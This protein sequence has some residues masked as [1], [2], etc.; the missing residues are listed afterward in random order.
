M[1]NTTIFAAISMA[2]VLSLLSCSDDL[3]T[4]LIE[5]PAAS[6]DKVILTINAGSPET[7]A[8]F[9]AKGN[10]GYPI[11][12]SETGE[13]IRVAEYINGGYPKHEANSSSCTV[14]NEGK[15]ASFSVVL[16]NE[17]TVGTYDYRVISRP[18]HNILFNDDCV[19]FDI[20]EH[21]VPT[22]SSPDPE[23]ILLYGESLGHTA[24]RTDAFSI[25]FR[26]LSAFG[27]VTIL[28]GNKP[29]GKTSYSYGGIVE[30]ITSITLTVPAGKEYYYWG[31]G[32][33]K[34]AASGVD[35]ITVSTE[36][37]NTSGDFEV[38]FAC[39]PYSLAAGD[40][41]T[42]MVN[43][44]L[45]LTYSRT[46]TL[47]SALS[48]SLG[49][50]SKFAVDMENAKLKNYAGKYLI[51]GR[52]Y[53]SNRWFLMGEM[54]SS[55]HFRAQATSLTETDP[56]KVKDASF[57]SELDIDD[58]IWQISFS[59]TA[60][61]YSFMKD[62]KYLAVSQYGLEWVTYEDYTNL[63]TYFTITENGDHEAIIT[64]MSKG[65]ELLFLRQ[66]D[67]DSYFGLISASGRR[68]FLIPASYDSRTKVTL[69]FAEATVDCAMDDD[70]SV[71]TVTSSASIS[72][73]TYSMTGD[74]IGTIDPATGKITLNHLPG[75]VTVKAS[76][77]GDENYKPANSSYTLNVKGNFDLVQSA[78]AF[79]VGGKYILA[80][81]DGSDGHYEFISSPPF[82]NTSP[83]GAY[84]NIASNAMAVTEG[85][86]STPIARYIFEVQSITAEG[87]SFVSYD[88]KYIHDY[89]NSYNE[90]STHYS[91]NSTAWTA[92]YLGS[93]S[94]TYKLVSPNGRF[95]S[96]CEN[97]TEA[98]NV[99]YHQLKAYPETN[100][101]DQVA[102]HKALANYSGAISVFRYRDGQTPVETLDAPVLTGNG[103]KV[104]MVSAKW[105]DDA[106]A[107]SGY[108]CELYT[109]G[110]KQAEQ[111][112][113]AGVENV[114][115]D[116]LT[117]PDG[118]TYTIKVN[119][120]AVNGAIPY[121]ASA[122]S[123]LDIVAK[124]YHA[125]DVTAPGK[126]II[127]GLTVVGVC[128][129]YQI[130]A[131]DNT[132]LVMIDTNY[133]QDDFYVGNIIT[134]NGQASWKNGTLRFGRK[135]CTKTGNA[136]TPTYSDPTTMTDEFLAAYAS[137]PSL[138][139]VS[140]TGVYDETFSYIHIGNRKLYLLN[141]QN[142]GYRGNAVYIEGYL[143]GYDS[144]TSRYEFIPTSITTKGTLQVTPK[145][146]EDVAAD[147]GT[148]E[149]TVSASGGSGDWTYS[150]YNG[151]PDWVQT[152]RNGNTL[153]IT[154]SKNTTNKT[155]DFIIDFQHTSYPELTRRIR[156][157]QKQ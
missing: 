147:G 64:S 138:V 113:A 141:Y 155:R 142:T 10:D 124:A 140:G 88:G 60:K 32:L 53:Y 109:G 46:I 106:R 48:F 108:H 49:N 13:R 41:L 97:K 84:C 123:S 92:T 16:T 25:D 87:I 65:S 34:H 94:G 11:T 52:D 118:T 54:V 127:E 77:A 105:T 132:G 71:Q 79:V 130:V 12:W 99:Y 134:V 1:K 157:F 143:Y 76:F 19:E 150:F 43:T 102:D 29:L 38:W 126:Y 93:A 151:A 80:F 121:A 18:D 107:S 129:Y 14:S 36:N 47:S 73:I 81:K 22:A 78:G 56:E 83:D 86:I 133:N 149:F 45:G 125:A 91:D 146:V 131:R 26:H 66:T 9:G 103:A 44:D 120:K 68:C 31:N 95:L 115:F 82:K 72:G 5:K 23:G 69:S 74:N 98:N 2:L 122:V 8:V 21:Q 7:K 61:G 3:Q 15:N 110:V 137:S 85:V 116:G 6:T 55:N 35:R 62:G 63:T 24:Q 112:V 27:R 30:H 148:V 57:K 114:T 117:T 96:W 128:G 50:V 42:V 152:S 90:A 37:L 33:Y 119:A 59:N 135:M 145:V 100:F 101:V 51:S 136:P 139:Y 40:E 75:T 28:N 153:S 17:T 89:N 154:I 104:S 58:Y 4:Q 39:A 20:P 111:D 144:S 156:V 67:T 70:S